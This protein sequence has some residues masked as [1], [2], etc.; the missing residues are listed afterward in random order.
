MNLYVG[1]D[2]SLAKL[3]VC[4]LT[5][6]EQFSILLERSFRN[7]HDGA[8]ELKEWILQAYQDY[9]FDRIVIGME[10]T[11]AYSFHPGYFFKEDPELSEMNVVVTIEEPSKIKKYREVFSENKNDA[12]DAFYIADYLR[13]QRFNL[14]FLKEDQYIA[15]QHL[16]RSRY[17]L[18]KQ[19]TTVKQH[20]LENLYYKCNTLSMNLKEDGHSTTALSA[21]VISLMTED[22]S[23]DDL[24]NMPLEELGQLIQKL[25]RG[26]FKAPEDLAKTIQKAIRSSYRLSKVHAQSIDIVLAVLVREIRSLEKAIKDLDKGI[27]D[28]V[29]ILPEYQ[30][31]TSIPGIGPVYAAGIIAEIG[32]IERFDSQAK[33]AKYA[34][35]SWKENQSG[36]RSSQ[37]TPMIHR[38][39]R[40]LRYYLV[41]AANSVKRYLPEYAQFYHKKFQEV[42]KH[43]HKRALV[44][45]ARKLV[46]LVDVLLRNHQ[47]YTPPEGLH[48]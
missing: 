23:L 27:E 34:G 29:Q 22:Y 20:F 41:E 12:L 46:R 28:I 48:R 19:L 4:C 6:D 43:Q 39:N 35:L 31:L 21:T 17:Q 15:L 36:K 44:L 9:H 1:L 32:Q 2:V 3:D 26:R 16:T 42:P 14:S 5:D 37:N 13:I 18:I 40:F 30:C 7:D 33:I 47:L 8:T 10:S 25:G 24:A 11:S 38:G 45:T